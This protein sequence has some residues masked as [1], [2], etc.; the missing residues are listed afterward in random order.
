MFCIYSR[1]S[2]EQAQS[3]NILCQV[4]SVGSAAAATAAASNEHTTPSDAHVTDLVLVAHQQL[5]A[6]PSAALAGVAVP[7]R[8]LA[9][10][11]QPV[12]WPPDDA[13]HTQ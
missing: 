12:L 6:L 10:R 13:K 5:C 7:V 4:A 9:G 11:Q 3:D 1:F 8:R 2:I